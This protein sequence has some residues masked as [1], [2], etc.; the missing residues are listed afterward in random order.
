MPPDPIF[1]RASGGRIL[2]KNTKIYLN[3]PEAFEEIILIF[4]Q[5]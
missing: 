4:I 5:T 1:I 2:L 3:R